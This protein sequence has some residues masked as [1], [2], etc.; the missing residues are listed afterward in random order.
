MTVP[1]I[2]RK[3]SL[4]NCDRPHG[5]RGLCDYHYNLVCKNGDLASLP[6]KPEQRC[7]VENCDNPFFARAWCEK[8]YARWR[9][10]P[11]KDPAT[12][13][14]I[15]PV[16]ETLE[17]RF[18]SKVDKDGSTMPHMT[19]PCWKWRGDK[20]GYPALTFEGKRYIVHRL[21]W[22]LANGRPPKD[23]LIIRHRCDNIYCCNPDHL[24]E[25]TDAD[26]TMDKMLRGRHKQAL[27]INNA[28]AVR[29]LLDQGYSRKAIVKLTGIR[30]QT[31][32]RIAQKISFQWLD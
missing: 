16:G 13:V 15:Y 22:E 32:W 3:C 25:G 14:H 6:Q 28:R 30:R 19:T 9:R 17:E 7:S 31:V 11:T 29:E 27:S 26:N 1:N 10:N 2:A 5:A 24:L 21:S 18:W 8:H 4:E 23:E 12:T 20:R